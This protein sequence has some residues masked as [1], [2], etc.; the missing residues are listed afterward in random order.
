LLGG[1]LRRAQEGLDLHEQRHTKTHSPC[2][3]MALFGHSQQRLCAACFVCKRAAE[4]QQGLDLHV[5][6]E[7]TH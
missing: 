4:Q 7:Q 2:V 1:K 6:H 3:N 5:P